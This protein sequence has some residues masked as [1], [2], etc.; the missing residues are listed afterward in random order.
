MNLNLAKFFGA[1]EPPDVDR[2]APYPDTRPRW[3]PQP[4]EPCTFPD[5][6]CVFFS[7]RF[8]PPRGTRA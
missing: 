1:W 2:F 7:L 6:F 4:L 3:T 8:R 5:R